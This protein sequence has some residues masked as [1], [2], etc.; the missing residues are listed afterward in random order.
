MV[1]LLQSKLSSEW[2]LHQEATNMTN[3]DEKSIVAGIEQF[4]KF[5]TLAN[6]AVQR[7]K[8]AEDEASYYKGQRDELEKQL[9]AHE[10]RHRTDLR[11]VSE[12]ENFIAH[13]MEQFRISYDRLKAGGYQKTNN[14]AVQDELERGLR[15]LN[16]GN[17][18]LSSAKLSNQIGSKGSV[19]P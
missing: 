15:Q 8:A 9:K 4:E 13:I 12:L 3:I 14:A 5:K 18:G 10:E 11:R 17:S 7:A 19:A 1:S 2:F 16:A 6:E